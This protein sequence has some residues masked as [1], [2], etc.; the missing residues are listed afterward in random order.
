MKIFKGILVLS[1]RGASVIEKLCRFCEDIRNF[2]H[3]AENFSE[4]F[5]STS[6][7]VYKYFNSGSDSSSDTTTII[8]RS[9]SICTN[10]IT[11]IK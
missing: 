11:V 7:S 8:F 9:G 5:K 4:M 3:S 6:Q 2:Y 1:F 10:N